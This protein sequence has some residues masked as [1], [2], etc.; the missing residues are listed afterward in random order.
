[1]T[2]TAGF[3]PPH[4]FVGQKSGVPGRADGAARR[5]GDREE[6]RAALLFDAAPRV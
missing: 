5:S 1:M 4:P 2:T 6:P 3:G